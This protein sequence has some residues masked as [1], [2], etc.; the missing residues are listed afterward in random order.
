M[1]CRQRVNPSYNQKW[2]EDEFNLLIRC[3]RILWPAV[4]PSIQGKCVSPEC[5]GQ[6]YYY[7]PTSKNSPKG[8]QSTTRN[9]TED[10]ANLMS[11]LSTS[12][13]VH[14]PPSRALV[15]TAITSWSSASWD[16]PLHCTPL[17]S[18]QTWERGIKTQ[19][20]GIIIPHQP[21]ECRHSVKPCLETGQ[22]EPLRREAKH[23]ESSVGRSIASWEVGIILFWCPLMK[24]PIK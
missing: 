14:P 19:E 22:E 6:E 5:N 9:G 8:F 10:G 17:Q 13:H 18:V 20:R 12:S 16:D 21:T 23:Q 2:D 11:F 3:R 24:R 15:V 4:P 1:S 7:V